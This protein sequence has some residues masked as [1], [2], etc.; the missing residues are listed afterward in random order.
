MKNSNNETADIGIGT[1]IIFIAMVLVAAVAAIVL[2]Y[3]AGE[4]QQKATITANEAPSKVTTNIFIES[5]FGDRVNSTMPGLQPGV[6]S[7]LIRIRPEVGTASMDLRQI[8]MTKMSSDEIEILNYSN[9][10]NTVNSFGASTIR[11]EDGSFTADFPVL[12]SGDLV[13]IEF[14][15]LDYTKPILIPRQ[16]ITLS[17]NQER[18]ASVTLELTGPNSFGNERYVKLYP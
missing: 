17:I 9:I 1:L 12:N 5:V 10:S 14:H 4:L 16:T 2:I 18:G 7:I 3:S 11:D 13:D 8:I 15:T 6:Q